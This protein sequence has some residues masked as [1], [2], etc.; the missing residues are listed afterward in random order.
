MAPPR[1]NKRVAPPTM[2]PRLPR[3]PPRQRR[4]A[5]FRMVCALR[6]QPMT[7]TLHNKKCIRNCKASK[8]KCDDGTFGTNQHPWEY[9]TYILSDSGRHT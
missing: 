6:H 7:K 2:A 4:H 8:R 9:Y 1:S 3:L 5:I